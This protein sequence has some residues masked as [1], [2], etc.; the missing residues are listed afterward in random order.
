LPAEN[1]DHEVRQACWGAFK[2]TYPDTYKEILDTWVEAQTCDGG[3]TVGQRQGLFNKLFL[4]VSSLVDVAASR[5][6]IQCA[7]VMTGS[8]VND[9]ASLG[10]VHETP[11]MQEVSFKYITD[12]GRD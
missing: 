9:D 4:Q 10:K 3:M 12:V 8:F 2:L 7:F 6:G 11:G 5:H 1:I